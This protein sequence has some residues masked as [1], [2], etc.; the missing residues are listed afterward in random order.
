L[1]PRPWRALIEA[2]MRMASHSA[3]AR[4]IADISRSTETLRDLGG[5][6]S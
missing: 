3:T 2:L 4:S 1:P 5:A 6:C